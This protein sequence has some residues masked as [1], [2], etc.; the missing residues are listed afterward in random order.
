MYPINEIPHQCCY[1]RKL[2]IFSVMNNKNNEKNNFFQPVRGGDRPH[3]PPM[4]PPLLNYETSMS[5]MTI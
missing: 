3:R 4:D 1:D 5:K 2:T